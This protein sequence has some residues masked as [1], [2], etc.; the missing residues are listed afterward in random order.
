VASPPRSKERTGAAQ[1]T[2][3]ARSP[4]ARVLDGATARRHRSRNSQAAALLR[5]LL[6]GHAA[7]ARLPTAVATT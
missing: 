1:T 7:A 4:T 3:V 6:A 5:R 2:A